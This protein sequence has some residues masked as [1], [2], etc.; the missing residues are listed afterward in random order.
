[1]NPASPVCFRT[2]AASALP[3]SRMLNLL[4]G[5]EPVV[6]FRAGFV[7]ALDVELVG[8]SPDLF[9]EGNGFDLRV[10][11]ACGDGDH[12]E[13]WVGSG[14]LVA[15]RQFR[16]VIGHRHIPLLLAS[17]T[18]AVSKKPIAKGAAAA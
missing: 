10:L 9:F 6:E 8:S 12:I 15:E 4:F 18:T 14:L 3:P 1:M 13:R 7:A 17:L 11:C 2:A 5:L 16:K